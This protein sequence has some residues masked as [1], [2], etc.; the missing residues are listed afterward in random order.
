MFLAS[1]RSLPFVAVLCHIRLFRHCTAFGAR[2]EDFCLLRCG[3]P[4]ASACMLV[5]RLVARRCGES[6]NSSRQATASRLRWR[7][8]SSWWATDGCRTDSSDDCRCANQRIAVGDLPTRERA[9]SRRF[10]DETK[11]TISLQSIAD[12]ERSQDPERTCDAVAT[13]E[14]LLWLYSSILAAL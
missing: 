12:G 7:W 14:A 9:K 10:P 11:V 2:F 8:L 4:G 3:H 1:S 13:M 5:R 6:W